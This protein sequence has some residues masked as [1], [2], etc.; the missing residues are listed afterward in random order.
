MA[1]GLSAGAISLIGAGA[2]LL[3]NSMNKDTNGGAG[4]KSTVPWEA[5]QPWLRNNIATGQK[6]Q[7]YYQQNP[8][9]QQQQNGINNTFADADQF[10]QSIAPG[11]MDF[12]N[13]GMGSQYH[14]ATGQALG[15]GRSGQVSPGGTQAGMYSNQG[16]LGGK[17]TG[18]FSVAQGTPFGQMDFAKNNPFTNGAIPAAVTPGA[19]V[20]PGMTQEEYMQWLRQNNQLGGDGGGSNGGIGGPGGIGGGSVW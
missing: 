20:Q 9:N 19:A 2:G 13:Q 11:L 4:T 7:D 3:G 1:F 18:P 5:A 10:R 12:A 17:S 8:F 6:L 14:R 16:L 15:S